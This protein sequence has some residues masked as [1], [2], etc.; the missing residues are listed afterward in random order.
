VEKCNAYA[1]N[2]FEH[3]HGG[4]DGIKR[5]LNLDWLASYLESKVGVV[6]YIS[7]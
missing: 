5:K 6:L 1:Q 4:G 2:K 7:L 3:D